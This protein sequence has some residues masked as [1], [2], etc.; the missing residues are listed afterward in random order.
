MASKIKFTFKMNP[1]SKGLEVVGA[2]T[3]DINILLKKEKIGYITFNNSWNS[4]V[5]KGIQVK[6]QTNNTK[7]GPEDPWRWATLKTPVFKDGDEAKAWVIENTETIFNFL[8]DDYKK[9]V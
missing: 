4:N 5:E 3:R 2:G 6:V 7:T 9:L 1:A 8:W